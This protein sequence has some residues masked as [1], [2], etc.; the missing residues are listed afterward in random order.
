MEPRTDQMAS[1]RPQPSLTAAAWIVASFAG[2]IVGFGVATYGQVYA[3]STFHPSAFLGAALVLLSAALAV[4]ALLEYRR[5]T[6]ATQISAVQTN[7]GLVTIIL[8]SWALLAMIFATGWRFPPT[9]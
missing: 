6:K 1:V 3:Q 7:L 5:T 4:L 8:T 2:Q 9:G